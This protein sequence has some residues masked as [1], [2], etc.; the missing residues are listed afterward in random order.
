MYISIIL[1][2]ECREVV[3]RM[4]RMGSTVKNEFDIVIGTMAKKTKERT[5]KNCVV[6]LVRKRICS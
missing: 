6:R 3:T 2:E 4:V 5:G 1:W